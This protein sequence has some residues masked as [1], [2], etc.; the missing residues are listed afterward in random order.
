MKKPKRS[1]N[2]PQLRWL[3]WFDTIN[4]KPAGI[5]S[6]EMKPDVRVNARN[7]D[8]AEIAASAEA[9]I[10]RHRIVFIYQ[11]GRVKEP[12]GKRPEEEDNSITT[13]PLATKPSQPQ[14]RPVILT[15]A[16][17]GG[18]PIDDSIFFDDSDD[19]P[20]NIVPVDLAPAS[21]GDDPPDDPPDDSPGESKSSTWVD[22]LLAGMRSERW[23]RREKKIKVS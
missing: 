2:K 7:K 8:E 6:F 3:A 5:V 20:S 19:D 12:S 15:P 17:G 21:G 13:R 11:A 22:K 10:P 4:F 16:F 1:K 23:K 14:I 18:G 9:Q